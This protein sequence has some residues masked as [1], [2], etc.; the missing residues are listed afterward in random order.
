MEHPLVSVPYALANG[1]LGM[2]DAEHPRHMARWMLRQD[3]KLSSNLVEAGG[4]WR[5]SNCGPTADRQVIF[6]PGHLM[7]HGAEVWPSATFTIALSLLASESRGR[8][9]IADADPLS[10][11]R[12]RYHMLSQANEMDAMVEAVLLAQEIAGSGPM[13][14]FTGAPA[15]AI[16]GTSD[17]KRLAAE[18]RRT[19][20]HTYHPAGTARSGS[21]C[22][23]GVRPRT[24]R[25]WCGG[26]ASR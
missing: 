15:G 24:A 2:F 5:S 17:P 1:H 26:P 25:P 21:A 23:G 8:V 18:I 20:Q 10:K 13:R 9:L 7:D 22:E 12:I 3:G 14:E 11:P 4:P 19:C 16:G 6:A